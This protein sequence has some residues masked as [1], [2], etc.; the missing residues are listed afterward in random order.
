MSRLS[1]ASGT[2]EAPALVW[3]GDDL[4]VDDNPALTAAAES[5][6]PV[7]ALFVLDQGTGRPPGG[8]ARWWLHHGL[9]AVRAELAALGIPLVLRTGPVSLAVPGFAAELEA[10]LVT[11]NQRADP[12]AREAE[13]RIEAALRADGRQA[14]R[15]LGDR[16]F[17]PGTVQTGAGKPFR[18]FTPFWRAAM[19]LPA[20]HRPKPAPRK[21]R[22]PADVPAGEAL[23]S[24]RLLPVAPD[25]AGGIA[26]EW[27]PGAR[28]AG[29]R[30]AAFLDD[31]LAGYAERRDDVGADATSGLSPYLRFGHLSPRRLF[32]AVRD[33]AGADGLDADGAKFL[34]ELGWREFC[35]ELLDQFPALHDEPID[36]RFTA[37]RWRDDPAGLAAWQQ[38]RT[39]IPL[40]DAAMRCLWQT[41]FI[42]NRARMVAASFLVKHLMI[43]WRA[44]ERWFWDTLVDADI[45]SNPASW[46]WVAGC[47]ADAAPFIRIFNPV[48][49]GERFDPAGRYV[50]RFVPELAG[51]PDS[52]I[53]RPWEAPADVLRAAGVR[54]GETYPRP[55]VDLDEGR[56]R[57]L[58]AFEDIR[59]DA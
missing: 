7:V 44:G 19:A 46:Q 2:D 39:G 4:R 1:S 51:L 18:V 25:W 5:G 49:Q 23:E 56:K 28:E 59:R 9:A 45:A 21:V 54:L 42:H 22:A 43:D 15:F 41:G 30:L 36:R 55:V 20:P 12:A 8:A 53:H 16:V 11:W 31:G 37:F 27:R 3:L 57:A 6:R 48:R 33:R 50:R 26:A 52:V 17:A 10:G 47:G 35:R 14:R 40:V 13:R 29:R 38:G 58:A 32:H 24:L 34:A